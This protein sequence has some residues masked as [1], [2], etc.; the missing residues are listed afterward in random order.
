[1]NEEVNR[2]APDRGSE[3]HEIIRF[4]RNRMAMLIVAVWAMTL[5]VVLTIAAVL[6]YLVDFHGF[7][8]LTGRGCEIAVLGLAG[9]FAIVTGSIALRKNRSSWLWA[10][11]GAATFFIGGIAIVCARVLCPK[12]RRPLAKNEWRDQRCPNCGDLLRLREDPLESLTFVRRRLV[13]FAAALSAMTLAGPRVYYAM[14]RDAAFFPS[15]ATVH[16]RFHTPWVSMTAQAVWS[17]ILVL[18]YS[19]VD[20]AEYTGFAVLLFSGFAVSALFVLRRRYPN[21]PRPFR[22]WG[23]PVAPA[24]FCLASLAITVFAI[25]GRPRQSLFG[26][27]IMA[28]GIPLY[29]WMKR[30]YAVRP[31]SSSQAPKP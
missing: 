28:A 19:S 10:I 9:F 7:V 1:M 4:T 22:A 11:L 2:A 29:L 23:Y 6:G 21:E 12:C 3:A 18:I 8:A 25:V 5:A 17:G 31:S 14:A 24:L 15:A 30:R 20:L 27:L 26:L 16:P 13:W